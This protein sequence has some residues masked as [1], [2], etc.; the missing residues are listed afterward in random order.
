[1]EEISVVVKQEVGKISWNFEEIKKN[2]AEQLEV[3]KK[4]IYTDDTIRSAKSDVATLRK[5]SKDIEDRRKEVKAKCLEPYNIIEAQAKELTTLIDEPIKA[6]NAQVEDY[7][8]RRKHAVREKIEGYWGKQSQKLPEDLRQK[9]HDKLYDSRWENATATMKS[10][11][12]AIDAGIE[13]ILNDI[14]TI[15]SFHSEYEEDMMQIY[16]EQ[17]NLQPAIMKMNQLNAQ[18]DRILEQERKKK[19]EAERKAAEEAARAAAQAEQNEK[20]HEVPQ[21][22]EEQKPQEAPVAPVEAKQ[23]PVEKQDG[24]S[25][26]VSLAVIGSAEQIDLIKK[27]IV[28]KGARWEEI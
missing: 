3:F 9:A 13:S 19:E 22:V 1:M 26:T 7:E 23:E 17:L 15:E 27:F 4:T 11:K 20:Q 14:Q 18:R 24:G 21:T 10:W 16:R 8:N 28:Y 12:D 6:I 2:L 5:L 25:V